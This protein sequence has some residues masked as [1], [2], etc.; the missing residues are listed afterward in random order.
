MIVAFLGRERAEVGASGRSRTVASLPP[1]VF[2]PVP[3]L[4][5]PVVRLRFLLRSTSP[6]WQNS[7]LPPGWTA[8][9]SCKAVLSSGVSGARR[10]DRLPLTRFRLADDDDAAVEIHVPYP[11]PDQLAP[12]RPGMGGHGDERVDPRMGGVLLGMCQQ[13]L[14]LVGLQ[15]EAPPIAPLPGRASDLPPRSGAG[16]PPGLEGRFLVGLGI[17][18]PVIG[19][20]PATSPILAAQFHAVRSETISL[21]IVA[22]L[23][24][25]P[26]VP[27][28]LA[29]RS[30]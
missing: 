17:A 30:T 27:F 12:P 29:R 2:G 7:A 15:V 11:H 25:L 19:N 3:P 18:Q 26:P 28:A 22:G 9:H 16:S 1:S 6:A 5:W 23:S 10:V 14:D 24:R 13:L 21:R 8:S 4:R 20:R